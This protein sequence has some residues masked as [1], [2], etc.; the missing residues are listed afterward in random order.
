[1]SNSG[2]SFPEDI[3][4]DQARTLG[5]RLVSALVRQLTG[6]IDLKRTPQPVFSI[7]FSET[8]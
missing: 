2:A 6:S 1:V 8:D 5:L 4:L 7:Y 3:E